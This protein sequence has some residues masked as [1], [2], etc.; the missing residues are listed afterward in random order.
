[1]KL[2]LELETL[3][4]TKINI[5]DD[6]QDMSGT[7]SAILIKYKELSVSLARELQKDA[8]KFSLKRYSNESKK[9]EQY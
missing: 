3:F 5:S 9:L 7:I 2:N 8:G 4:A 6:L 1:M